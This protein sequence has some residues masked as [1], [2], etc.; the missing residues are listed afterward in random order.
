MIDVICVAVKYLVFQYIQC[1][2]LQYSLQDDRTALHI[3]AAGGHSEIVGQLLDDVVDV[4]LQD[5]V[6]KL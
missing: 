6:S 5:R 1:F 4:N 3:A 2:Q